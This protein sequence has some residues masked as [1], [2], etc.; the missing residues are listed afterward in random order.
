MKMAQPGDTVLLAGKGA[1]TYQEI[2]GE[3]HPFDDALVARSALK[4]LGHKM[5]LAKEEH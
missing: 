1:E 4:K 3:R 5:E 2:R